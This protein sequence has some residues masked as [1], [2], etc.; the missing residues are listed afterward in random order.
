MHNECVENLG[1]EKNH[2]DLILAVDVLECVSYPVVF[3]SALRNFLK[4]NG[5]I[6]LEVPNEKSLRLRAA[7]RRILKLH[8]KMP[9]HPGHVNFFTPKTLEKTISFSGY[10]PVLLRQYSIA[11][12]NYRM[13]STLKQ[14]FAWTAGLLSKFLMVSKI[15]L[16]FG[17]GNLIVVGQVP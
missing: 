14:N 16:M 4:K 17:L 5:K 7:V 15:D 9:V 2:F 1:L 13:E 6:Y 10:D 3:L 8:G 11:S 12:D